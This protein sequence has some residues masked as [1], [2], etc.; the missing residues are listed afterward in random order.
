MSTINNAIYDEFADTWWDENDFLHLLKS[1]VNPWRVP[2]FKQALIEHYDQEISRVRL[3]DIGCGGGVLTEEYA[4]MGCQVTGI[5]VS[6]KSISVAETHAAANRLPIK[7]K[8]GSGTQLPF[9]DQ[10]FDVV[11]CCDVLEHIT[12]W[13]MVIA[14]TR[15]VLKP[16]GPFLFD[17]VNR[18]IESRIAFIY[19]LQVLP[20][21]RL[22]PANTHVWDMFIKPVELTRVV[23]Q[24][25]MTVQDLKG[26]QIASNPISILWNIALQKTG[27]INFAELGRRLK[28]KLSQDLSLNYLGYARRRM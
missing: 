16:G 23:E 11:S 18:T 1:M 15:R 20:F 27:R 6:A 28:L 26:G 14:E 9:E 21:T 13:R 4:L 24:N 19:G 8:I 2:Y 17:T 22:M 12:D 5:D 3:L 25:G 10:S 7:Y